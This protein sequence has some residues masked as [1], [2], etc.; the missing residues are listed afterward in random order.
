MKPSPW[1]GHAARSGVSIT[2]QRA[3]S[4]FSLSVVLA[5]AAALASPAV[6]ADPLQVGSGGASRGEYEQVRRNPSYGERRWQFTII[7]YF[8]TSR[9]DGSSSLGS[10]ATDVSADARFLLDKFEYGF[11]FHIEARNQGYPLTVMFDYSRIE[12]GDT[13]TLPDDPDTRLRWSFEDSM[14][15]LLGAYRLDRNPRRW[16][17]LLGGVRVRDLAAGADVT[18]GTEASGRIDADWVDPIVGGRVIQTLSPS[19]VGILRGDVGGFGAG[20]DF[21]WNVVGGVGF[22]AGSIIIALEYRYL[23]VDYSEGED[24]ERFTWD[25]AQQGIMLGIGFQF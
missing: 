15:E 7:P 17:E 13:Q 19:F 4:A 21:S 24:R 3:R 14:W 20:A 12:I 6:A 8:Q 2:V 18:G 22:T 11:A 1:A 10:I 16:V 9:L 25:V 23:D 5:A